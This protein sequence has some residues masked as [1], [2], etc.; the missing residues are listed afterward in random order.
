M[1]YWNYV[2]YGPWG[3]T[4]GQAHPA[5]PPPG[6]AYG[7]T[8]YDPTTDPNWA[9]A[10]ALVLSTVQSVLGVDD[11]FDQIAKQVI[12]HLRRQGFID[13]RLAERVVRRDFLE[14]LRAWVRQ[15]LYYMDVNALIDLATRQLVHAAR[16]IQKSPFD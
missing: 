2:D 15:A 11:L 6:T 16:T 1:S 7:Y 13:S 3:Y 5:P 12:Q 8:S 10:R 4:V 14:R 9:G